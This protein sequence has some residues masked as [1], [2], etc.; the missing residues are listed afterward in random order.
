MLRFRKNQAVVWV[1]AVATTLL[2]SGCGADE[3]SESTVS[4]VTT[5]NVRT[6]TTTVV[7]SESDLPQVAEAAKDDLD[8]FTVTTTIVPEDAL[9][10]I[11]TTTVPTTTTTTAA[12]T[13]TTTAG[14][15]ETG[16]EV[17]TVEV[18]DLKATVL[19]YKYP[20]DGVVEYAYSSTNDYSLFY[21][22]ERS[23]LRWEGS[24]RYE[25]FVRYLTGPGSDSDTTSITIEI[26]RN[27]VEGRHLIDGV[28]PSDHPD[29][30][31]AVPGD[32]WTPE[33]VEAVIVDQRGNVLEAPVM[34]ASTLN[35][36]PSFFGYIHTSIRSGV[37]G[38]P[39]G[40][41]FPD[42]PVTVGDSWTEVITS[43]EVGGPVVITATHDLVDAEVI[44]GRELL[45]VNSEYVFE[46]FE[47]DFSDL[48]PGFMEASRSGEPDAAGVREALPGYLLKYVGRD[49]TV[50]A[51]TF[52]DPETGL[53]VQG[54]ISDSEAVVR[55]I[56]TPIENLSLTLHLYENIENRYQITFPIAGER[57]FV[58]VANSNQE[59][60]YALV[61]PDQE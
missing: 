29:A 24:F 38:R 54:E 14:S 40:P 35:N 7:S 25:G 60:S 37:F 56:R 4:P 10:G 21:A 23:D 20:A 11:T 50:R 18:P 32:S 22:A 36:N 52:F 34:S 2:G 12:P 42:S 6:T 30:E 48:M 39:F 61:V 44:L 55:E 3:T 43:E 53:V 17:A 47:W 19:V 57:P 31:P 15:V 58:T 1:L 45:V 33:P 46:R 27:I 51:V 28:K 5:S 26:E 16:D 13:T 59:V 9:P 41:A 49:A 8:T